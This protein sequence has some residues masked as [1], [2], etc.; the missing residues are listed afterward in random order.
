M[1]RATAEQVIEV[2]TDYNDAASLSPFIQAA[3]LL[4][5]RI[6]AKDATVADGLLLEIERWLAAHFYSVRE[7]Q[8]ASERAGEVGENKQYWVGYG[9]QTTM[10]GSQAIMLDPTGLL[11]ELNS[12]AKASI[13]ELKKSGTVVGVSFVGTRTDE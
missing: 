4:V 7:Q 5:D 11:A 10:Y 9:F 2:L 1:A 6:E 3:T 8:V 12:K 13:G